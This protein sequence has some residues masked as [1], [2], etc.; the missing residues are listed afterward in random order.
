M[1]DK[2]FNIIQGKAQCQQFIQILVYCVNGLNRAVFVL[3]KRAFALN[4]RYDSVLFKNIVG[5]FY[6]SARN[7]V[8]IE[9]ILA[10]GK[11]V[12]WI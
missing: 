12:P 6:G 9:E 5:V 10:G 2:P 1:A 4:Y 3:Y 7:A 8:I 11:S